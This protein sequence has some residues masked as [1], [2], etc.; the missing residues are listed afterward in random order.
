MSKPFGERL[1]NPADTELTIQK[2]EVLLQVLGFLEILKT[3]ESGKMARISSELTELLADEGNLSKI[4]KAR[5]LDQLLAVLVRLNK[6]R[7]VKVYERGCLERKFPALAQ[8][9]FIK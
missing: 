1:L 9:K 3:G 4:L 7:M 5:D 2:D 6:H 8:S